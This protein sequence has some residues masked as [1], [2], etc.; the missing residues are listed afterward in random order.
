MDFEWDDEKER[1]NLAKHGVTFDDATLVFADP[2]VILIPDRV[3]DD[4]EERWLALGL[5]AGVW[6]P[7]VV[8]HVYRESKDG[9]EIIRIISARQAGPRE[10]R[11][12]LQ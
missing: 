4:G 10:S 12:Y 6:P 5:S 8:V 1:A 7:L 3:D 9:H 2:D 11:R